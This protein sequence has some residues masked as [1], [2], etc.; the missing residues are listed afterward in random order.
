MGSIKLFRSPVG[1]LIVINSLIFV[2]IR[3]LCAT[4]GDQWLTIPAV[5]SSWQLFISKPWTIV[6]YMFSQFDVWQ[7][8]FNMLWLWWT[9]NMLASLRG[10]SKVIITYLAGGVTGALAFILYNIAD[11]GAGSLIGSS[12]SVLAVMTCVA[13]VAPSLPVNLLFFGRVKL[14]WVVVVSVL[15]YAIGSD[16]NAPAACVAH[17]AGAIAGCVAGILLRHRIKPARRGANLSLGKDDELILN[18]LL[19]KVRRSGYTS[20]TPSERILL[21]DITKRIGK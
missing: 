14:K 17:L 20:L 3:V 16:F 19:D 10:N 7:L 11:R 9:G 2:C 5:S 18:G 21:I 8:V 13:V 4:D 12:C 6:T 1:L 15:L